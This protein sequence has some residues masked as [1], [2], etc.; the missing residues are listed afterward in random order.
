MKGLLITT[1]LLSAH[2]VLA[3]VQSQIETEK[4]IDLQT[5]YQSP[6][7]ADLTLIENLLSGMDFRL[8]DAVIPSQ[9]E[10]T[11]SDSYYVTLDL[12]VTDQYDQQSTISLFT[13]DD[14]SAGDG[15]V[16]ISKEFYVSGFEMFKALEPNL[17]EIE[18]SSKI[19]LS[20][21]LHKSNTA[22]TD[23]RKLGEAVSLDDQSSIYSTQVS[24][25]ESNM[26]FKQ[27]IDLPETFSHLDNSE[28]T[29]LG[30][31]LFFR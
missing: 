9:S 5:Q 31:G 27:D 19:H 17:Y 7:A 12:V 23:G 20:V 22:L 29:D 2:L 3:D 11:S 21:N 18:S 28:I 6:Q 13:S 4:N 25:Q 10:I 15:Y 26:G 8:Q 16:S 14:F 24:F 1:L 30:F